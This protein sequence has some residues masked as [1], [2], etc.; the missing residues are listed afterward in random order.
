MEKPILKNEIQA[1]ITTIGTVEDNISEAKEYALELKD[2]YSKL[3]F[4]EEQKDEAA[5]ERANINKAIKKIA[6]YR[7][8]IISEFKKPIEVFETTAKET[9][10]IL[11]ETSDF[12][13][14]QVKNFENKEKNIRKENAKKIY[15]ENIEEL[16]DVVPFEKIFNE[17]WLNKGSW[18]ENNTSP[19][20]EEEINTIKEKVRMGLKAIEELHSEFELEVKNTFLQDYSLENAIF[21][22]T[23]LIERKK[24]LSKVEEKKEE[25]VQTKVETMLKEEVKEDVSDPV[26]TYTLKITAPLTKQKALKEFLILNKMTFEKID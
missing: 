6:D 10:K 24:T 13:D 17:K 8:N 4:T 5:N 19:M 2:Y 11:K 25:V 9:E 23:Q 12:V 3:V 21:K 15:E 1:K 16:K 18:K 14:L 26:M 20:I 7:K 22:N